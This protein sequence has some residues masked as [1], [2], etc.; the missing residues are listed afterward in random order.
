M[1]KIALLGATGSIGQQTLEIIEQNP[2]LFAVEVLTANNNADLLIEQARKFMPNVVIISNEA[3]YEQV[4]NALAQLPI[5]VYAGCDAIAQ[6]VERARLIP[7]SLPWLV[8]QVC[9]PPCVR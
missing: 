8:F 1:K 2:D 3:K 7:S 5:K 6:V 9:C 4:C